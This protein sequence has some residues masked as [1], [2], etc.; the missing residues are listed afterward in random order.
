MGKHVWVKSGNRR[1]GRWLGIVDDVEYKCKN[2]GKTEW[3][4]Y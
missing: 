1:E 2:C 4:L 3:R